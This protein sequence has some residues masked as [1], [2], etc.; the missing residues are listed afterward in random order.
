M[1]VSP[2]KRTRTSIPFSQKEIVE[3][4]VGDG[5]TDN[6]FL[7]MS[8]GDTPITKEI[9]VVAT[10]GATETTPLI[11][12]SA[13][14]ETVNLTKKLRVKTAVT[15]PPS[16]ESD[17]S[18]AKDDG[19]DSTQQAQKDFETPRMT[20]IS[21]ERATHDNLSFKEKAVEI[22][23]CL[24]PIEENVV[25]LWQLRQLALTK[26]GLVS[27][28][29]R[30]IAWPK[31]AGVHK[32]FDIVGSW[33]SFD[34]SNTYDTVD[35]AEKEV[36]MRDIGRSVWHN[37]IELKR[38][39]D[40]DGLPSSPFSASPTSLG[41]FTND[42][43]FPKRNE[44]LEHDNP[45]SPDLMR[46]HEKEK[47]GFNRSKTKRSATTREQEEQHLLAH[48]ILS[49]LN[50]HN[51]NLHYYQGFHD[52]SALV[53]INMED[54]G[55]A[56]CVLQNIGL[57]HLRDAMNSDFKQ[58]MTM[59]K[60]TLFPLIAF[61]DSELHDYLI[62]SEV[63]PFFC[64]SWIITWFCHDVR[65]IG[66][67]S[68]YFDA[69]V[70]SHPL[71]PL[72]VTTAMLI[73]PENRILLLSTECDF[74][75]IHNA[76]AKLP[77]MVPPEYENK[78]VHDYD[79]N[80]IDTGISIM[81][82]VPPK[83]LTTLVSFYRK[84]IMKSFIDTASS[85][86]MFKT[87]PA[88]CYS[89]AAPTERVLQE[90]SKALRK[91]SRKLRHIRLKKGEK[92]PS[93]ARKVEDMVRGQICS[94]P[95]ITFKP[96][97]IRYKKALTASGMRHRYVN[98]NKKLK[99]KVVALSSFLVIIVAV[100]ITNFRV[101]INVSQSEGTSILLDESVI[102]ST[103]KD[104]LGRLVNDDEIDSKDNFS[105]DMHL[106]NT[107]KKFAL[108]YPGG[109]HEW[110]KCG[111][112]D[113][114]SDKV[115]DFRAEM[116]ETSQLLVGQ[117]KQTV[118]E[119]ETKDS[120]E[121]IAESSLSSDSLDE[122]ENVLHTDDELKS[123]E[124]PSYDLHSSNKEKNILLLYPGAI[125]ESNKRVTT[126]MRNENEIDSVLGNSQSLVD[127]SES[128]FQVLKSEERTDII[129]ESSASLGSLNDD[130]DKIH[131]NEISL[132]SQSTI[133]V[134][135]HEEDAIVAADDHVKESTLFSEIYEDLDE[136]VEG[137][138]RQL[139]SP[140]QEISLSED[141]SEFCNPPIS[142]IFLLQKIKTFTCPHL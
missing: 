89:A 50:E 81:A 83:R 60:M 45:V 65:D 29:I 61:I 90:E 39:R 12:K 4:N 108:L 43:Y 13:V 72:Y 59:I 135:N 114:K 9:A 127:Q 107:D 63:E 37:E 77:S 102:D 115:I 124:K 88:W 106:S 44:D 125:H 31:L 103:L 38:K 41:S 55:L 24:D 18:D 97:P 36:V 87:P 92:Q 70:A 79:Q 99:R 34:V 116:S 133:F 56:S 30:K 62:A 112:T 48:V 111:K 136:S 110:N 71:L 25:D 20:G 118:K 85:I 82:K 139:V 104:D 84:G 76:L 138:V 42:V 8:V 137:D 78:D 22:I 3:D 93:S 52:L 101:T 14:I 49:V 100:G 53:I 15:P 96:F 19:E 73:H 130:N 132:D 26:G 140:L 113:I 67:A 91:L 16:E 35:Q 141:E 129:A 86:H 17:L 6:A 122:V 7:E 95:S 28:E 94:R 131:T 1:D 66:R 74:A 98:P 123:I 80:L 105:C 2:A 126:D 23:A 109:I 68:R 51:G 32:T 57:S 5:N 33:K 64:L 54:C 21:L 121:I 128:T 119:L 11:S 47:G 69:F 46:T 75:E 58:L 142:S 10:D 120:T 117:S 134:H 27:A 40:I